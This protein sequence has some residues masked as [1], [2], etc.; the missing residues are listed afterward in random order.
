[1]KWLPKALIVLCISAATFMALANEKATPVNINTASAEQL[2]ELK[3]IGLNK[4]KAIV[5]YR[6]DKGPFSSVNELILVKGI[7]ESTL[8]NNDGMLVTTTEQ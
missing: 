1:M 8:K 4:A 3:G 6:K 2:T 7:G 5:Q